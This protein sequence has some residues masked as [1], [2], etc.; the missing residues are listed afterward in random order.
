MI[1]DEKPAASRKQILSKINGVDAVYWATQVR[2]DK[3]MLDA[4]GIVIPELLTK[5]IVSEV[6]ILG[7]Q[8]KIVAT[9]SAGVNQIDIAEL[10]KRGIKLGN[11]PLVLN[12][13]V[14]DTAVLLALAAARRLHEGRLKI[15]K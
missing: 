14:A 4:A 12:N 3:E 2:L 6:I 5:K 11:T 8:L 10:K 1:C 9:M 7:P 13:T 15:E